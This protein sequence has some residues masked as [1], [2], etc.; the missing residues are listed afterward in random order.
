MYLPADVEKGLKEIGGL[1]EL[2]AKLPD[3]SDLRGDANHHKALSDPVR[4]KILWSLSKADLCPCVLKKI[5]RAP[6][7]KLSYHLYV[8]QLAR[9]IEAR[10]SK[11][12]RIYSISPL[13]KKAL[14]VTT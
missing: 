3:G 9:L 14:S 4:L 8:L 12:W 5:T 13:G 11:S 7:S 6:D 2:L 10:R 1:E